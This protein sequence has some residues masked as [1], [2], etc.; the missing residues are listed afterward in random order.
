MKETIFAL[1]TVPGLSAIAVFR[2]SG[3]NAFSV[4]RNI[5][6]GNIP[7][8]R[9]ATLKKI[10]WKGEVID[11]CIIITF[12][13]NESYSGEKTVEIH[14]HGSLAIIEKLTSIL[15]LCGP[16]LN[17]RPAE[18]GEFTRQAFYNGKMDLIQV[19]GLSELLRAETEAQRKISFDSLDGVVSK[20]VD[21]WKSKILSILAFLEA[22]IDFNDQDLGE[23]SILNKISDLIELLKIEQD[24]FKDIRS[25]KEGLEI[26]IIGPPNVGKSTLINNMVKRNVSLTSRIA[27]TT[28]DIIEAK[29]QI[30]GVYVTFLD[31]AGLR[32]TKDTIE[33]KGISIMK[34]RLKTVA[35]KIFLI[36]RESD[37]KSIGVKVGPDDLILKA[38]ADRGNNTKYIGISGKTGLGVKDAIDLIGTKLPQFYVNSGVIATYRQQ[39]K[40]NDLLSLLTDLTTDIKSGLDVELVAEKARDGLK[41]VGELTGRIDTEEVWVLYSK[42]FA[43]VSFT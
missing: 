38:K 41:I 28:R 27:G 26:A 4:L 16:K 43:E 20:K 13:K 11:Q 21:T 22:D 36:N 6:K 2:I 23:I 17:I 31:T 7:K 5:T 18:E 37:L 10:F 40:T 12:K 19:E 29:V 9:L 24:G 14:C 33:K 1:S 34:K 39:I 15:T 3:P 42:V 35:L 32:D 30:N 25:I 8:N